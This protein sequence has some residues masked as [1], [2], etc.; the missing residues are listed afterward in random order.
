VGDRLVRIAGDD[1]GYTFRLCR[2]V[3]HAPEG[4]ETAADILKGGRKRKRELLLTEHGFTF[5]SMSTVLKE[6]LGKPASAMAWWG[7]RIGMNGLAA[8][9]AEGEAPAGLDAED[10]EALL[11]ERGVNPNM[12][13]DEASDRGN[14]A[15]G[16][17]ELLADGEAKNWEAIT[18]AIE[19]E[20]AEQG[21]SYGRAVVDWWGEKI[22]PYID[23]GEIVEVR[24]EVP[25]WY[26][27]TWRRRTAGS[28]DLAIHWVQLDDE[29]QVW[30]DLGWEIVDLKTHKPARGFTKPKQGPAYIS[31]VA[32]I[33]GYRMGWEFMGYGPT[34]R[35]RVVIAREKSVRGK[36]WLE[37]WRTVSEDFVL[38]VRELYEHMQ[39]FN[40]GS[41]E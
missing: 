28:L 21:T 9:L 40:E 31:D 6:V 8:A 20:E 3:E 17:L 29:G 38:L 7:F 35:Q 41:E 39:E 18:T 33:R 24:S 2:V 26:A 16:I 30:N 15:H 13:T 19:T 34:Y 14:L 1:P 37:D 11:K 22:Q 4:E 23:S 36:S 12:A 5:P 27:P 25:V 10:L 32:Q